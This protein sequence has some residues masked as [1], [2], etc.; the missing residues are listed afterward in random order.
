MYL[1]PNEV[2]LNID[3]M[4]DD[5]MTTDE[6]ENEIDEIETSI[7]EAIPKINRIYLEAET[8]S[9]SELPQNKF[10]VID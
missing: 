4:F 3:I 7:T 9:K 1:G 5:E 2:L 6:I 10:K 8:I